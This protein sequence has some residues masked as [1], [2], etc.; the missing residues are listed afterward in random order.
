M[1]S[2][3]VKK[4]VSD[5]IWYSWAN[6]YL[7]WFPWAC[8][9]CISCNW[10][11]TIQVDSKNIHFMSLHESPPSLKSLFYQ[12]FPVW[13]LNWLGKILSSYKPKLAF[14]AITSNSV[15]CPIISASPICSSLCKIIYRLVLILLPCSSE[16]EH[17]K[18]NLNV[19]Y[20]VP[21]KPK[22][23]K[24]KKKKKVGK[25]SVKREHLLDL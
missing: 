19:I 14:T 22:Q 12:W 7:C 3:K 24:K 2:L 18:G 8:N 4:K 11:F 25:C 10:L 5:T 6:E 13:M 15:L 23:M 1:I 20:G 16:E 17:S 21:K 9:E